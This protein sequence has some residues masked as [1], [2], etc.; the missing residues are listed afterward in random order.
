MATVGNKLITKEMQWHANMTEQNH[1]GLALLTKPEVLNKTMDRLF[2]TTNYATN[3]FTSI[4]SNIP[5]GKRTISSTE[6]EWELKGASM[7]P[8]VV[9]ET[10]YNAETNEPGKY[11]RPFSLVLDENWYV[12]GD[13]LSPGTSDKKYLVRIQEEVRRRGTSWEYICVLITNNREEFVPVEYLEPGQKW[14]KLFSQYEE[15]AEQSG[16]TQYSLPIAFRNRMG[17]FRKEYKITDL[18][19]T[20]VLRVAI[21]DSNGTYHNS[22]M[23]YAEVEFWKEWYQELEKAFWYM[24]SSDTVMGANGRPVRM[25]P[26]LQEQLEDSHIYHY[27]QL[28]AKLIEEYLMDIFYGRIA[29]GKGRNVKA[30]TG[31]YG[32]LQFHRAI[33]DLVNKGGFIKNIDQFTS[34]STSNLNPNSKQFGYQWVKYN[35]ANGSSLEL[36]HNPLYDDRTINTEIDPISGYPVESQ[37]FTFLDFSGEGGSNNIQLIE[38]DRSF[39]YGYVCGLFGPAGPTK[40]GM[41]A[42]SGSYYEMHCTKMMG[43]HINDVTKCGELILSRN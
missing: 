28:S 42:H 9:T 37:R 20:E 12:P 4:L 1:L 11:G 29:P 22:W 23:S 8:L 19:L 41:M 33:E 27:S 10:C 16:S 36:I 30:F 5:H 32:M 17:L 2:A 6:W 35:M 43:V 3:P 26:G 14:I 40:G 39:A 25:G 13:V 24:R 38:K 18:A 15:A 34:S 31:E 7:R 21:P